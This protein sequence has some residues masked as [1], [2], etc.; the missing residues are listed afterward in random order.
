VCYNVEGFKYGNEN[1][2][3][4]MEGLASAIQAGKTT[5]L[6]GVHREEVEAFE[7]V[8]SGFKVKYSAPSGM[9]DDTVNAHALAFRKLQ[10]MV[11]TNLGRTHVMRIR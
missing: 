1:K 8:Y 6:E 10:S 4:I 3:Q 5:V 9:H 2:Q 11:G 7:F